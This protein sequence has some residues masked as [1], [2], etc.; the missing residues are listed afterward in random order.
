MYNCSFIR[1]LFR[2]HVYEM[3][4][5]NNN[6]QQLSIANACKDLYR[7]NCLFQS[8]LCINLITISYKMH[9][10]LNVQ[11]H[12]S[13]SYKRLYIQ[14]SSIVQNTQF[15]IITKYKARGGCYSSD[16]KCIHKK[17]KRF[18]IF[19]VLEVRPAVHGSNQQRRHRYD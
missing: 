18:K 12:S 11:S 17:S 15:I 4:I 19:Y 5:I 2:L 1:S 3:F 14:C 16:K 8:H 10:S 13:K 9:K 6:T 7:F